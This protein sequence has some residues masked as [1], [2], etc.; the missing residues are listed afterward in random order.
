MLRLVTAGE[1]HGMCLT[2]ILEGLP[3]GLPIDPVFI[4]NQ[5]RRRQL[6]YGR[7][8]RMRIEKDK[9]EIT[10][11]VRH[12]RTTGSPVS[13][14]IENKDWKN[15]KETMSAEPPDDP[16]ASKAVTRPRPGHA[17]LAG[18]VKFLTH[19]SRDVLE[20]ASARETAARVAA[21]AFCSQLLKQFGIHA[22]SHVIAIGSERVAA[23]YESLTT[24]AIMQIDPG[25][26][27][28][29]ADPEVQIRMQGVID[30]ARK[31]GDSLGG[32]V[33]V[34]AAS[35]PMGLGSHSQW[36]RK[37]DGLIAQAC[38]SIPSVKAVEIGTG[39]AAAGQA[40]SK[41][42]DEIFYDAEKEGFYRE[43]NRAGG[44]EAGITNGEDLLVRLYFKPIPTLRKPLRSVDLKTKESFAAAYERSDTCVVPAGG[45]IAE[46]MLSLVL[47][48][49]FLEK[50]G[51]DSLDEVKQNYSNYQKMVKDY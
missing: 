35:V 20:R 43:T 17:D 3:A 19:D 41:V 37:L 31:A 22:A 12:G 33:E 25:S 36:D 11:G 49:A 28:R 16:A 14:R 27:L 10:S 50:F 7:G 44:L 13:F 9:I 18:A 4:N 45:V 29:C 51:G 21:G 24:A 8:G 34:V 32:V 15:W 2:G 23:G 47:S 6:G 5:L 48:R 42:H 30:E 26:P 40:G 1:S 38:M 39:I 46:A